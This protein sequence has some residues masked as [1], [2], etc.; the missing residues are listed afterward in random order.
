[1]K[2]FLHYGVKSIILTFF[3][4][5]ILINA[6]AQRQISLTGFSDDV[7]ADPVLN[8]NPN[9]LVTVALD[10]ADKTAGYI[11]Y[12]QGYSNN[13]VA[14]SDGLP[15]SGMFTSIGGHP[16]Q[17]ASY[18]ASNVLHLASGSS[19]DTLFFS[20]ADQMKYDSIF[21]LANGGS[22]NPIIGYSLNFSDNSSFTGTFHVSD[23]YCPGCSIPTLAINNIGRVDVASGV[24][25]SSN[26]A[27]YEY[28]ITLSAGDAGKTLTSISFSEGL[29]ESGFG[30]I[31]AITGYPPSS[32]PVTLEYFNASV[33]DNEALL[34][35]KTAQ[36]FNNNKFIIERASLSQPNDFS[37]VGTVNASAS[38]L[39]HVYTFTNNPGVSGTYIYRLKQ[40]DIDGNT[41]IIGVQKITL[42]GLA[43]WRILNLRNQWRIISENNFVYRVIDLS[44]RIISAASAT[45]NVTI[46]KPE[47][48]GIYIIQV[49]SGGVI[50]SQKVIK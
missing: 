16:Y 42:N 27:M 19:N 44:G 24:Y 7:L 21:I 5:L 20:P 26:F 10:K 41:K 46:E 12:T 36:E 3:A 45:G 43:R 35:W 1:M 14:D 39:S 25:N 13:A 37:V 34:Q 29:S 32:L 4:Q 8:T 40:Q 48:N 33:S 30:N 49:Q 28:K 31:F 9:S 23:W 2:H 22:G 38:Y 17:L 50:T 47:A 18:N 11:F 6:H 15:V